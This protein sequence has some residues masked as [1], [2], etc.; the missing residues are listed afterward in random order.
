MPEPGQALYNSLLQREMQVCKDTGAHHTIFPPCQ[1]AEIH[2]WKPITSKPQL[3][4]FKVTMGIFS[5]DSHC[6]GLEQ[7]EWSDPREAMWNPEG[8]SHESWDHPQDS[9]YRS[10]LV[11]S[12]SEMLCTDD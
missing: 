5:K 10:E 4:S 3:V 2:I 8:L 12:T 6:S 9:G 7:L 11:D 1:A